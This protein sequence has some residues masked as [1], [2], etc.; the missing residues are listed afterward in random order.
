[1]KSSFERLINLH[2]FLA[3]VSR[4]GTTYET[5]LKVMRRYIEVNELQLE[6]DEDSVDFKVPHSPLVLAGFPVPLKRGDKIKESIFG[7]THTIMAAE[8]L[9]VSGVCVGYNVR[10]GT[11]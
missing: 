10:C 11:Q 6:V 8:P 4:P 3:T 7:E 5:S 2:G 1:M 9:I